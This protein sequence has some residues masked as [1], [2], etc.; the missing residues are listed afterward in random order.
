MEGKTKGKYLG[1]DLN[2]ML[3]KETSSKE[4]TNPS[5]LKGSDSNAEVHEIYTFIE[6]DLGGDNTVDREEDKKKFKRKISF[7]NHRG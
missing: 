3:K 1:D 6:Q 5:S 4:A 2:Q 7:V